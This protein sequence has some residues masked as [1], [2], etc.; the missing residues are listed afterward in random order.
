MTYLLGDGPL[1][2]FTKETSNLLPEERSR[3]LSEARA[4]AEIHTESA[5]VGQTAVSE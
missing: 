5:H 1:S 4:I 2:Q 3:V